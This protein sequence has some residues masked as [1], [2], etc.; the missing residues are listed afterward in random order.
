[1]AF[2]GG[3]DNQGLMSEINVTP[4][5][6]VML[7]LLIIFM[8]TAPMMM[9]GMDVELPQVDAGAV[10]AEG[11]QVV[12]TVNAQGEVFLDEFPVGLPD[13]SHKIKRMLEVKK[14]RIIYL[15]AD[16]KAPYGFVAQI[17]GQVRA[18]GINNLGLVTEPETV[19][20]PGEAAPE[21]GEE[22]ASPDKAS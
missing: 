13:L 21:E 16:K 15:R 6:D 18:A 22:K 9:Q 19:K 7:V 12:I 10:R 17:M 5:V 11:E 2:S 4:L 1:M 3:G 20:G 8:V 14:T